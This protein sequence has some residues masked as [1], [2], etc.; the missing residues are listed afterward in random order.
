MAKIRSLKIESVKITGDPDA[1]QES[2]DEV[3]EEL[4]QIAEKAN[5][6]LKRV[7]QARNE[8]QG[9]GGGPGAPG[10]GGS[11]AGLVAG[12]AGRPVFGLAAK[13]RALGGALIKGGLALHIVGA[14]LNAGADVRDKYNEIIARGISFSEAA[15]EI[16]GQK[17]RP[18]AEVFATA[19]G[20]KSLAKGVMR[21]SGLSE[22]DADKEIERFFDKIFKTTEELKRLEDEQ[23]ARLQQLYA[24]IDARYAQRWAN[25]ETQLPKSFRLAERGDVTRFRRELKYA[26]SKGGYSN[27]EI[28]EIERKSDRSM[29]K[30]K[31]MQEMKGR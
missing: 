15:R 6:A 18:I 4:D 1:F 27:Y 29:A 26:K 25:V 10:G 20:A 17:T 3:Q 8:A 5:Q 19:T 16:G 21:A 13:A 22:K 28:S 11:G 14:G 2:A 24:E 31:H 23:K 30:F 7:R 9:L 12:A